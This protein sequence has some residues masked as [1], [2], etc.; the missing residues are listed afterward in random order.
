[1]LEPSPPAVSEQ[2][3]LA[4]DPLDGPADAVR[5]FGEGERTW[6]ALA[7]NDPDLA[8]WCTERWLG[9]WPRLT[10]LPPAWVTTRENLHRLAAYVIA[11]ARRAANGKIGLRYTHGGF[12]TPFFADD[13]QVRVDD[14]D[15]VVVS[16]AQVMRRRITSL[17]D[18]GEFVGI[19]PDVGQADD[20]SDLPRPGDIDAALDIDPLA[21][22]ALGDWF[23]FAYSVLEELRSTVDAGEEPTRV[24]IWPEHFDAAFD[25]GSDADRRR[26]GFG[27]SPGDAEHPE[28]YAYVLPWSGLPDDGAFWI[29]TPFVGARLGYATITAMDDQ[30]AGVLAFFTDAHRRIAAR[31][32]RP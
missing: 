32:D 31:T 7:R 16:G 27:M 15:L 22:R 26:A 21:A 4:D 17:A 14:G 23:G 18:A 20:V 19:V 3:W 30:R 1:V 24:Q 8:A 10:A 9:P 11:P 2:P 13:R 12:G 28:P 25:F 6:A 5:P 29:T